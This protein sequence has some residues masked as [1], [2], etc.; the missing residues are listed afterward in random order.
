MNKFNLIVLF[1][2]I[3]LVVYGQNV[4]ML[5]INEA[6]KIALENA[7]SIKNL[8][9]DEEIQYFKNKE[10]EAT[11]M[12][13]I[14]ANGQLSYYF[15]TP[16]IQFPNSNFGIYEVLQK[17]GVKD[18]N[19][20]PLDVSKAT[21]STQNVSFFA[22]LNLQ[23]GL[24]VNQ[25]L[26]Q[27]DVFVAFKAR[28]EILNL[29]KATTAVE[30]SKAVDMVKKSYYNVLIAEKQKTV[31][32]ES[33]KR[34]E[35][36]TAEMGQMFK[37]GFVERLDVDKLQVS[38]NNA[39]TALNQISNGI[40]IS[41][42]ALKSTMGIPLTDS[43]T[44]TDDLDVNTLK[45]LLLVNDS[46]FNYD[47][48][49]EIG[50]L[51]TAKKLQ[52][53]DLLRQEYGKYP[54]VAAFI[55]MTRSGQRN[56]QFNPQDPWFFFN[57]GIMGL[58]VNQPIFDG[59]QRKNKIAQ[60]KLAMSKIDNNIAQV[61]K[62]IDLEKS[63]A[64]TSLSNAILNLEV[65]ERNINLAQSVFNTTKKKYDAGVGSSLE[66][67]LAETEMQKAQGGFFQALYEG[68]LAKNAWDKA[69]GKL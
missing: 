36:L 59:G 62:F 8:K 29:T 34:L 58:S 45:A 44:L 67:I 20:N 48:R 54:T 6:V 22:P 23:F 52:S 3:S 40:I 41:K 30:V 19:G 12:P 17:E 35:K 21:F 68:Y 26:F 63:I 43:I 53:L 51:N 13:Q 28:E 10:I 11:A 65:Q 37:Q 2:F 60:S 64:M 1:T 15:A 9:L 66:L 56:A 25:L 49:K 31:L 27:P 4:R 5:T 14:S 33:L 46:D 47:N 42:T 39:Q 24:S 38:V 7:E 50:I 69:T 16:Q 18:G 32:Q 55:N 57:T 61:K